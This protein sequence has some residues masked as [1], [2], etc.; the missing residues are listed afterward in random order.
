MMTVSLCMIVK[1]EEDVLAR[2]LESVKDIMD[3]IIIV[4]TGSQD[5]TKEI[6]AEFT[7]R[8]Y[9]F[10]W[11]DDF[12]AARNFAFSKAK[13]DYTIWLDADDIMLPADQKAFAELKQ[14]LSQDT[15]AVKMRY[16]VGF[17]QAGNPTYSFFRERLV[18]TEK[19][20]RWVGAIHETIAISGNII[21]SEI[22]VC[23]KKLAVKDAMRNLRIYEKQIAK[24]NKLCPRDQFYYARELTYH[25]RDLEAVPILENLLTK[26]EAWIENQLEA[27]RLLGQ[28]YHRMEN[29]RMRVYSLVRSFDLDAPRAEICCDLG[30]SFFDRQQYETAIFWYETALTR[31]RQDASGGFVSPDCYGFYPHIQLCVCYSRMGNNKKANTHNEKAGK[32]KPESIAVQSNRKFFASLKKK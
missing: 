25:D 14:T 23:H 9:D 8:V 11:I 29:E 10:E 3:E 20:F 24:G 5:R 15:D 26:N 30:D 12:A 19:K 17:D 13:M 31:K 1:N 16:H 2:C 22:A 4:D 21:Y 28:C 27:C 6:A 7:D 18:R 32:F